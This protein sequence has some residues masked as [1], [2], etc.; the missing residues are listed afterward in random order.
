MPN[1]FYCTIGDKAANFDEHETN[2]LK[3]VRKN[4]GDEVFCTDGKGYKYT[5]KLNKIGK[6]RSFGQI[7]ESKYIEDRDPF[8]LILFAP[9]GKW[10]RLR[11]LLEKSVELG[12]D[13]VFITKTAFSNR[14]YTNKK[15]K[16]EL[17]IRDSCKQCIRYNFPE[18]EIIDFANIFKFTPKNTFFLDFNGENFPENIESDVAL[19]VGPEGGFTEDEI[20]LL[21]KNF[22]SLTLGKKILRFETA[23]LVSLSYFAIKLSKI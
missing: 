23:A 21:R 6:K 5:V 17:V 14:N 3:V 15:E 20:N 11:W 2:H 12:V 9:S 10:E 16:I 19:I 7:L 4:V 22:K 8:K 1:I 13:K 18:F